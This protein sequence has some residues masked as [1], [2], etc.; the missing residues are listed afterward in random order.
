MWPMKYDCPYELTPFR[1]A[2]AI[3]AAGMAVSIISL[4][5]VKRSNGMNFT[6]AAVSPE[7]RNFMTGPTR[8]AIAPFASANPTMH[9]KA[10]RKCSLYGGR[11]LRIL[12]YRFIPLL[13]PR[14]PLLS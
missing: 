10:E 3:M 5:T 12:R 8:Y 7:K 13:W 14:G 6:G 11:R 1:S 2:T 9:T 4:G